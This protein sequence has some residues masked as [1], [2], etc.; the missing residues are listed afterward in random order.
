MQLCVEICFLP[1]PSSHCSNSGFRSRAMPA[2][3]LPRRRGG[4]ALLGPIL[5]EPAYD[6]DTDGRAG[7][8][9]PGETP[10]MAGLAGCVDAPNRERAY[11]PRHSRQCDGQT[12]GRSQGGRA[13]GRAA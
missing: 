13:W 6:T 7:H 2:G 1:I 9:P 12:V 10:V 3:L 8:Q 4:G 5:D 11:R